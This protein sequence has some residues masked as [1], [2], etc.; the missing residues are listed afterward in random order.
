MHFALMR[1]LF[2]TWTSADNSSNVARVVCKW[3][4]RVSWQHQ[5][6]KRARESFDP[7]RAGSSWNGVCK[8][9]PKVFR[10]RV[11]DFPTHTRENRWKFSCFLLRLAHTAGSWVHN[12][13]QLENESSAAR[14][15]NG[16][17]SSCRYSHTDTN[18]T[19]HVAFST[20]SLSHFHMKTHF[21]LCWWKFPRLFFFISMK[22]FVRFGQEGWGWRGDNELVEKLAAVARLSRSCARVGHKKFFLPFLASR[23]EEDGRNRR[24]RMR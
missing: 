8:H 23:L 14:H 16:P 19:F 21:F 5:Q 1:K 3:Q 20:L 18:H 6:W 15:W 22:T 7:C 13:V 2:I 4:I 10:R 17:F 24:K 9:C 11:Y 12:E